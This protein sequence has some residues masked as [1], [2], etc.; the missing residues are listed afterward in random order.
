LDQQAEAGDP[1]SGAGGEAM[2]GWG[3]TNG[4]SSFPD[5]AL[6]DLGEEYYISD[7]YWFDTNGVG[8][9][10]FSYES[11]GQYIEFDHVETNSY[12]FGNH[13]RRDS[14]PAI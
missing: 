8:N 7:F 11:N 1:R 10:T 3:S 12:K 4:G 2:T 5:E 6:L 9:Y 14:L 13:P